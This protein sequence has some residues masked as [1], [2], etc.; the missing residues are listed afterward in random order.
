MAIAAIV[1]VV[2]VIVI[3]AFWTCTPSYAYLTGRTVDWSRWDHL[4]AEEAEIAPAALR[5]ICGA[6]LLRD[7]DMFR[8][9]REDR[10]ADV[11]TA[12]YPGSPMPQCDACEFE[13]LVVDLERQFKV[14]EARLQEAWEFTVGD[15]LDLCAE[16]SRPTT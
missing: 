1:I 16:A 7:S 11:Y 8:L 14:T 2:G 9:R 15:V 13:T 3:Q 4:T 6:F 10:L 5:L 12:A